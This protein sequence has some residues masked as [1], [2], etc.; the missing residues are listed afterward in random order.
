M[1]VRDLVKGSLRLIG[2]LATGET[3][4]ADE[5]VDA[6]AVLNEML[7]SWSTENL[8]ILNKVIESFVLNSGQGTYMMGLTAAAGNFITA[9]AMRIENANI[10]SGSS[11]YPIAIL[12]QDEWAQ[13]QI[14]T[15]TSNLP[16]KIY[17]EGTYPLETIHVWP[18]PSAAPTLVL[19]SW[20]ALA[21][22]VT[23]NDTVDLAPGYLKALRFNLAL[24][25]CPEYGK[26][27]DTA[28]IAGALES[29]ENIKRMNIKPQLMHVDAA[30]L[31]RR[32]YNIITGE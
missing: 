6:M 10:M 15:T 24:A 5:Q 2:A 30:L 14:K 17:A 3:P 20:K 4:S 9:R 22:F 21:E 29:K 12:T 16:T 28:V 1:T 7:D 8:T 19:Y 18:V 25:L 26:Q 23:V 27:P 11:E 32:T 13:V 31:K